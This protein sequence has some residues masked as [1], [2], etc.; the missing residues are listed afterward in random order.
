MPSFAQF[1]TLGVRSL[2]APTSES[3]HCHQGP[4]PTKREETSRSKKPRH[5]LSARPRVFGAITWESEQVNG[6][7]KNAEQRDACNR[8][9]DVTNDG[10]DASFGH[11]AL[12]TCAGSNVMWRI[13]EPPAQ[14]QLSAIMRHT[15]H[16]SNERPPPPNCG[17]SSGAA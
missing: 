7:P 12:F 10:Q 15:G 16:R 4:K 11:R 3:C 8:K 14:R 9:C 6:Y 13:G 5:D 2:P 17:H 1:Q